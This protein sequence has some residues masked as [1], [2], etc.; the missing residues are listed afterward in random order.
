MQYA[1]PML[2]DEP[3][4][5]ATNA[6]SLTDF[7]GLT[8]QRPFYSAR[9]W[10]ALIKKGVVPSIRLPK[11]RRLI[12]DLDAVDAALRRHARGGDQ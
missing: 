10:R 3:L 4:P 8:E 6:T 9:T 11:A 5:D 1:L 7:K 12:I 2:Q